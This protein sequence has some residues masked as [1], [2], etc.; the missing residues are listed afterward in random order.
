MADSSTAAAGLPRTADG[1]YDGLYAAPVYAQVSI[2]TRL[3]PLQ[4]ECALL[5]SASQ[6]RIRPP[7][8][9]AKLVLPRRCASV[10][11]AVAGGARR[12]A[13]CGGAGMGGAMRNSRLPTSCQ[14]RRRP[15][16]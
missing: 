16:F 1:L 2:D 9:P 10:E 14:R 3:V 13:S 12:G 7:A 6:R 4:K 8:P 15:S 11:C 5:A